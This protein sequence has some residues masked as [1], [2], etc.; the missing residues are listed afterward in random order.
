M[1]ILISSLLLALL[2]FLHLYG[3]EATAAY[4]EAM[5]SALAQMKRAED[6]E[7]RA[8]VVNTF[9]RIGEA[10]PGEWLPAY[11]KNLMRL[12]SLADPGA[13]PE[14][15]IRKDKL[16]E[17]VLA[18][19]DRQLAQHPGNS[20]LLTLKGYHHLL[21]VAADPV[22]RGAQY[23][24]RTIAVLQQAIAADPQNPRAYLLLGQMRLGMAQFMNASTREACEL[25]GKANEYYAA[26]G[27]K[28][29]SLQPG[30]GANTAKKMLE[31]CLPA[32]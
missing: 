31:H 25:I 12:N 26:E 24:G 18:D 8:A 2:P 3:Q 21:Y 1:K 19:L 32:K 17:E 15:G 20:E 5:Q 11:Y 13:G 9:S 28:K 22:N 29:P 30:W 6:P 16:L 14:A 4:P 7:A 23:S 10:M 27:L